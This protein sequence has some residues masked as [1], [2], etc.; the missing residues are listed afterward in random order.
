[1][2][3]GADLTIQANIAPISGSFQ[4][5]NVASLCRPHSVV[6][7]SQSIFAHNYFK[8]QIFKSKQIQPAAEKKDSQHEHRVLRR[9]PG[10]FVLW[11]SHEVATSLTPHNGAGTQQALRHLRLGRGVFRCHHV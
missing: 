5:K 3:L 7:A 6:L 8:L 2:V 4:S 10:R 9:R 11:P 1:M